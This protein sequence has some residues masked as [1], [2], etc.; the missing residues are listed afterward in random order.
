MAGGPLVA[1]FARSGAFIN[2]P[3][4]ER[5]GYPTFRTERERWG[6]QFFLLKPRVKGVGQSPP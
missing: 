5:L 4:C 6:T 2:Q 3:M 1:S